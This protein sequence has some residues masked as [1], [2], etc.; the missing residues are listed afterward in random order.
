ML[1]VLCVPTFCKQSWQTAL[2]KAS[3]VHQGRVGLDLQARLREHAG[4]LAERHCKQVTT[5]KTN[6]SGCRSSKRCMLGT[7]QLLARAVR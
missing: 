1:D 3:A 4:H 7:A 6:E 5:S 2:C